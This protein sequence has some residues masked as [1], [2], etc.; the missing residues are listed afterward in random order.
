MSNEIKTNSVSTRPDIREVE[1]G[2]KNPRTIKIYPLSMQD[3]TELIESVQEIIMS[4][5]KD[6]DFANMTNS[7]AL[8]FLEKIIKDNLGKILEYITTEEER[9][10]FSELTN[11]Q[12]VAIV[13]IIFE[14]NYEETL[15]NSKD[16][17]QKVQ[18]ILSMK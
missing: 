9:P 5:S 7:E 18:K 4:F 2:I 14:V 15:K 17:F 16:L 1:I 13:Q 11:N 8:S 10:T 12:F 6:N 3:Q